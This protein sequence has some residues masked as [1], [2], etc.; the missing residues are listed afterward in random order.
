[1][2]EARQWLPGPAADPEPETESRPSAGGRGA[3]PRILL[4]DDNPDMRDYLRRLL[5]ERYESRAVD[6]D[7]ES[8]LVAEADAGLMTALLGNLLGNAWKFTSRRAGARIQFGSEDR[9][10]A[11][12]FFVRDNGAGFD[13][14]GAEAMFAPFR[15]LHRDSEYQGQGIGLATVHRIVS[16]YGGRVW[17]DG[18]VDAGATLF[19]TLAPDD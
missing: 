3:R 13:V 7:I 5:L 6:V 2:A 1:M 10:G 8:G 14:A 12:V 17:A 16:R 11:V 19:F 15:R 18:A 4:A 9:A